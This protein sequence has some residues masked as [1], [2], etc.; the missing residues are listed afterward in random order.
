M[1]VFRG[2]AVPCSKCH[3]RRVSEIALLWRE[4]G[5]STVRFVSR[6]PP[7]HGSQTRPDLAAG[8]FLCEF[9]AVLRLQAIFCRC[10]HQ[11]RRPVGS[12][13]C[14]AFFTK[15]PRQIWGP[16]FFGQPNDPCDLRVDLCQPARQLD[17]SR[18]SSCLTL[19]STVAFKPSSRN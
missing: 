8:V 10:R 15:F 3:S 7:W 11:P 9:V 17:A 4:R 2:A 19:V 14:T 16:L 1:W 6:W 13:L 18:L 12:A 5:S